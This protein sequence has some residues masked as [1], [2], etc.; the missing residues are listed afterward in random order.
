MDAFS[1]T[2]IELTGHI[3]IFN[4]ILPFPPS[5][6][7]YLIHNGKR[8]ILTEKAREFREEVTVIVDKTSNYIGVNWPL[9][10]IMDL[11]MP[12][13]RQRDIDNYIKQPLDALQNAGLYLNDTQVET[14]IVNRKKPTPL[15]KGKCFIKVL[16]DYAA[17]DIARP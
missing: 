5:T 16:A 11:Y 4:A 13:K 9:I 2:D 10:V 12:D 1:H 14:L 3:E 6:N 8:K 7:H 15:L 17:V